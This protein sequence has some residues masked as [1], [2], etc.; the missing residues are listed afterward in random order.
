MQYIVLDLE[1][2]QSPTGKKNTV[3]EIPFEII[4]IGAVKLDSNFNI[5]DEFNMNIRPQVY[6]KLHSKVEEVVSVTIQELLETGVEF[7]KGACEFIDWCGNNYIFCTWGSMDITEFERNMAYYKIENTF[8]KPLLFY[9]LQKLFSICFSDGKTRITLEHAIEQ[10]GINSDE[11]Y[12]RAVNDARYTAKVMQHLD[13]NRAGKYYSVDTFRIPANRKEQIYLDFGD[14]GKFISKGFET[15][16]DAVVDRD[17]R[18]C[19]C[20]KCK[21]SMKKHIKWFATNSKT[22]Y[23]LF[24]CEKHGLIKGRFKAKQADNG[25]FYVVKILKCTDEYGAEKVKAKQ[26]KERLHRKMRAEKEAENKQQ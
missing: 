18:S 26:E 2:N 25:L 22:Y 24:S 17:V 15:R 3:S 9:D 23:G 13:M 10:L 8:E 14:Y 11:Q 12:H 4:Q 20:F 7:E 5:I 21:K 1:W 6:M 19:K 16:E